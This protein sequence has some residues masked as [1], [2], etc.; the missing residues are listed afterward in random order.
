MHRRPQSAVRP[1]QVPVSTGPPKPKPEWDSTMTE[2]PH[3]LSRA[4][5][6]QKKLNSK[7]KNEFVAK[8][9]L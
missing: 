7:S 2:N 1:K 5:L 9:E 8:E 3:K 4:E 6:L